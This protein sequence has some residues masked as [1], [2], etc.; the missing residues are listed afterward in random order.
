MGRSTFP[1]PPRARQS[2]R[3]RAPASI[4]LGAQTLTLT[5]ASGTFSGVIADGGLFGGVGGALTIGGGTET[6]TGTNTYT[7]ATTVDLGATLKLGNGGTTGTVAGA[8]ADN[9]LVQFDCVGAGDD[10]RSSFSGS[11]IGRGRSPGRLVVTGASAVGGTVTIDPGRDDAVGRRRSGVPGR[12]RQ[13]WPSIT[14]R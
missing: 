11:R 3:W 1:E 7:G 9:G 14:A 5:N 2:P 10:R 13:R 6:L 8:I 4:S 12:R